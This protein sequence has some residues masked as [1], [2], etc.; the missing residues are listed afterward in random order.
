[1]LYFNLT[2]AIG[3]LIAAADNFLWQSCTL[4]RL[5]RPTAPQPTLFDFIAMILRI[6]S[7]KPEGSVAV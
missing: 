2:P 1:M 6:Q 5:E 7:P 4:E 3:V